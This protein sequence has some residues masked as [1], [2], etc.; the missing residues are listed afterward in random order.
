MSDVFTAPPG[1]NGITIK[2]WNCIEREY[3]ARSFPARKI[4]QAGWD[5][6]SPLEHK[7]WGTLVIFPEG[8]VHPSVR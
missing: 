2:Q 7:F 8:Y 5:G 1:I 6:S 4:P 3:F